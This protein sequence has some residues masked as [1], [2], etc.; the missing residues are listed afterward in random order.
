MKISLRAIIAAAVVTGL[1]PLSALDLQPPV[2]D[3]NK[4]AAKPAAPK[5]K[6]QTKGAT[7]QIAAKKPEPKIE[8]VY[9][10]EPAVAKQANVNIRG[11]SQINAE[12][13]G[14]LKRG[15]PVTIL[16]EINL[17]NAKQDEPSRWYRIMLPP[18]VGAWVNSSFVTNDAVKATELNLRGGPGEEYPVLGRIKRGTAVKQLG[19][20]I[21]DWVKIE[22]P[23]NA[24]GFVAAHLL[25]KIP[26]AIAV[27]PAIT[28]SNEVAVAPTTTEV[29]TPPPPVTAETTTI[30]PVKPNPGAE[31]IAPPVVPVVPVFDPNAPIE[32]V[33]K[34]VTRE[35]ILK[36]SVSIQAPTYFE[37]R[38][39]DTGKT[40]NYVFSPSTNLVL[41]E[42]KGKR[43]IV[44]GEELLDER[45]QNTPVIIVDALQTVP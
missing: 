14:H 43:I 39:L 7:T 44:T 20:N 30:P 28:K 21:G 24:Y 19:T 17:K 32:K 11:R 2:T 33:K 41:K 27:A 36:G 16:E 12:I 1:T 5:Q 34:V 42:F 4:P 29:K 25:E 23:T 37:L 8:P 10:P 9:H 35:G 40:I 3:T 31:V 6:V 15:E 18:H 22:A 45:W 26:V 38:A 13:V